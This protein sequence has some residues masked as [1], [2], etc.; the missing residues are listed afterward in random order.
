MT[1]R[2]YLDSNIVIYYVEGAA[3]LHDKVDVLLN[4]YIR[5]GRNFHISEMTLGECLIGTGNKSHATPD[6]YLSVLE[7]RALIS[8]A[9]ITNAIIRRAAHLD[10]DLNMKLVDAIHV[11]TAEALSCRV[12]ITNDR[13]I[14]AP[15]GIELRYL[16]AEA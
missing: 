16:P 1:D 3:S 4:T 2:V 6:A 12:L 15:V 11:A 10:A 7:D 9:P 5:K 14:R 8:L 13:G